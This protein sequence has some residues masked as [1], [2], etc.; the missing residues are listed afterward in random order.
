MS[1]AARR[2]SAISSGRRSRTRSSA[3]WSP[4]PGARLSRPAE[5]EAAIEAGQAAIAAGA[6]A[7]GI[8]RLREAVALT[9]G[10]RDAVRARALLGLAAAQAHSAGDRSL[11]CTAGLQEAHILATES[12]EERIA[13][14]AARELGFMHVQMGRRPRAEVWLDRAEELTDDPKERSR[15]LGVRG[16]SRSDEGRGDDAVEVLER[17]VSLAREAG[18]R[19]SEVFSSALIGRVAVLRGDFGEAERRLQYAADLAAA[20]RWTAFAPW[21]QALLAEVELADGDLAAA[22]E[23]LERAYAAS[24]AIGDHCWISMNARGLARVNAGAGDFPAAL[25]WIREALRPQAWYLWVRGYSLRAAVEIAGAAEA[26]EAPA[27]ERELAVVSARA[28]LGRL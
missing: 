4:R 12:G 6:V 3:R 23:R 17:S 26:E 16:M 9:A 8:E 15:I 21:I 19:R 24:T 7:Y 20:E 11:T 10:T 27:W 18:A 1:S 25:D 5:A 28:E 2:C 14:E 22:G 13:A